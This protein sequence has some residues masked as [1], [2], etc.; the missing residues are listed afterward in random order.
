MQTPVPENKATKCT[1]GLKQDL[2]ACADLVDWCVS[3]PEQ[4]QKRKQASARAK[5]DKAAPKLLAVSM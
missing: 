1:C 5:R 3:M 2:L 4:E